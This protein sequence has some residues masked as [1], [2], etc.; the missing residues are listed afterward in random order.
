MIRKSLLLL[1]LLAAF[2]PQLAAG[3]S[4]MVL[5]HNGALYG[6]NIGETGLVVTVTSPNE[7]EVP[8]A[9]TVPGTA[10]DEIKNAIIGIDDPSDLLV[11][12]WQERVADA[13]TRIQL[14]TFH[15]GTWF[16]PVTVAGDPSTWASNPAM[17]VH[18]AVTQTEE[19]GITETAFIHL[20]WW[21]GSNL[22]DGGGAKGA[23]IPID[24]GVPLIDEYDP[25]DLSDMIPYGIAC[26]M[27]GKDETLKHPKLFIDPQTGA[28]HMIFV[29]LRDCLFGIVRLEPEAPS[30]AVAGQRRRNIA[31]WRAQMII[32]VHPDLV[33]AGAKF[34]VGHDLSVVMYW[35][36]D[37]AIDYAVLSSSSWS[38]IRSLQLSNELT[39][40]EGVTLIRELAR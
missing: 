37:Q 20:G 13:F 40:E 22:D 39:H 5:G 17:L 25:I 3:A 16:G 14:A 30:A 32:P 31:V 38:E 35:D 9:V 12:V 1:V 23:S 7:H 36:R 19:S 8:A 11:L 28:P 2:G 6:V 10:G 26:D 33:L 27:T 18:R 4:S 29:D 24:Q 34:D 21:S 15:E